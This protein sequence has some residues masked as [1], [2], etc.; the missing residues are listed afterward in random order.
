MRYNYIS[1]Q[2]GAI[3]RGLLVARLIP[4]PLEGCE[5]Q[6]EKNSMAAIKVIV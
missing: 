4:P 5:G 3:N 1:I 6:N 2:G